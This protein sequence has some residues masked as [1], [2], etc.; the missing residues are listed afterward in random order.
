MQDADT[1]NDEERK[2]LYTQLFALAQKLE[3]LDAEFSFYT[4]SLSFL[5]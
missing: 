3:Q 1:M 2:E 5:G 4:V